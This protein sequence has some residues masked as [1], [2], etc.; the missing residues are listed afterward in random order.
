MRDEHE[1]QQHRAH[2]RLDRRW[3][4]EECADTGV[5]SKFQVMRSSERL[6]FVISKTAV[7]RRD[8]PDYAL[9]KSCFHSSGVGEARPVA[10]PTPKSASAAASQRSA[11]TSALATPP[12]PLSP[13]HASGDVAA[14]AALKG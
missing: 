4:G 9:A 10:V 12:R 1:R 6:K 8:G 3:A 5:R 2:V 14:K 11:S 13:A 7:A